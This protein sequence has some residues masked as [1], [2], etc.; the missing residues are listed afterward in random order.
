MK[1]HGEGDLLEALTI[2]SHFNT[3]RSVNSWISRS[4]AAGLWMSISVS[5]GEASMLLGLQSLRHPASTSCHD[6]RFLDNFHGERRGE[7][8]SYISVAN[9]RVSPANILQ[10][11][12]QC[13]GI[14]AWFTGIPVF[15]CACT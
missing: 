15:V 2:Q 3:G 4:F 14:C 9:F 13:M 10:H 1:D 5:K 12:V 7:V 8:I 6:L 11:W